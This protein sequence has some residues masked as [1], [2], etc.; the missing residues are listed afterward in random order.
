[1]PNTP[2]IK[3][4]EKKKKNCIKRNGNMHYYLQGGANPK[5]YMMRREVFFFEPG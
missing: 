3:A 4:S 5:M 2:Y 1:M